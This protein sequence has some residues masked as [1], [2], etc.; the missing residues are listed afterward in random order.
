MPITNNYAQTLTNY[1]MELKG[2]NQLDVSL[3]NSESSDDSVDFGT[4]Y[5]GALDK[6]DASVAKTNQNTPALITGEL[7]NL[8]TMMIDMTE[9]QLTLQSAIQVRN[10]CVESYNEIKNMQF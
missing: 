10:K 3:K 4:V 5:K 2:L 9:A 7:D 8:H 6:L 1:Q